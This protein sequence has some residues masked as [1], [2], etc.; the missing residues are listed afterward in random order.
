MVQTGGEDKQEIAG[1]SNG[2]VTNI[3]REVLTK[4]NGIL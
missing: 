2:L 3:I 4:R 1:N